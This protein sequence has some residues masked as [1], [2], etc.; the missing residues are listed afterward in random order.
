MSKN[1]PVI[2]ISSSV[3]DHN[4]IPS[5]HLHEKYI[6]SVQEAGGIPFVIPLGPKEMTEIW[7]SMC[8]GLILS[9]G[10]DVDPFSYG[11]NPEPGLRKTK[12]QRDTTENHLIEAAYKEE[13]P[14]F[15]ICRGIA[16]LNTA[17]GG[18]VIQDI[19]TAIEEPIKHYQ[20]A[21]RPTPT[22]DVTVS[23]NSMLYDLVG[24]SNIQVNSMHH[25]AIG[26][27]APAL[28]AVA[29]APDGVVEAVEGKESQKPMIIGV[30][31]HP[32]E[33]ALE[34]ETMLRIFERF[35]RECKSEF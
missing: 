22:H 7:V 23:E 18:T 34:N 15:A 8:D 35:V 30:Q 25:Q 13:K 4:G 29:H 27:I 28:Q 21:A 31:W 5:V 1:K 33:M 2:G 26:K 11:S 10:E 20:K 32:E 19:E 3:V 9:G 16:M 14:I 17:L 6:L 12:R 24:S